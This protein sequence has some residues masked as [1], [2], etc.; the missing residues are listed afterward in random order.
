[1]SDQPINPNPGAERDPRNFVGRADTSRRAEEML[2]AGQNILLSDPRRMGKTFWMLTFASRQEAADRYRVV[3]VDYQG[4]NSTEEFLTKT[5]QALA[6]CLS[7]PQRFR[8]RLEALFDNVDL[9]ASVG[10]FQ[11]KTA[12]QSSKTPVEIMESLLV[13]LDRDLADDPKAP[14]LVIAMDEVSD[15][16]MSIAR[17][18]ADDARNLLQRLRHLRGVTRRI[19][20]IIAGSIGFHHIL[21]AAGVSSDVINDLSNLDFGPLAHAD[22]AELAR[23]LAMG[24]RRPTI[25]DEAVETV[26]Q[27]TDAFPS[28][29]QKLFDMMR[30][31][32]DS[33]PAEKIPIEAEEVKQ[34]LDDFI[35]DR[36]QSRDVTHFVTRITPYYGQNAALAFR[37][38]NYMARAD[39]WVALPELEAAVA[40]ETGDSFD[41]E[42]FVATYNN[43]VDDHY[44]V[45]R[46]SRGDSTWRYA[47]IRTIY[48]RR[49][50]LL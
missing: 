27:V 12:V 2:R 26:V 40:A 9:T 24:I 37:I 18:S 47:V 35:D 43:L 41:R 38:L 44:L 30:Y 13:D 4:V 46:A 16:I 36:D 23:R 10:L 29:I 31:D 19:R 6:D 49:R 45:E 5:A 17:C 14:T 39:G 1:M 21:A 25:T 28:L 50:K 11:L 20:W 33:H 15:A 7:L 48:R 22:A 32:R 34:R 42:A 3:F 8:S